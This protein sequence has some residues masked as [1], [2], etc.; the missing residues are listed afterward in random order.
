MEPT[1][2]QSLEVLTAICEE[3]PMKGKERDIVRQHIQ[4]I[5][6]ALPQTAISAPGAPEVVVETKA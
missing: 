2:V 3:V 6:K 1:A 4:N 5:L